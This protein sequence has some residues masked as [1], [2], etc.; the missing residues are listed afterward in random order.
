MDVDRNTPVVA[1]TKT[2]ITPRFRG[3]RYLGVA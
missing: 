1:E 3:A 2:V